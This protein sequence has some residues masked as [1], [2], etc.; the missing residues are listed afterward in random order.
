MKKVSSWKVKSQL[1]VRRQW[2]LDPEAMVGRVLLS[3][4]LVSCLAI[5][6][7]STSIAGISPTPTAVAPENKEALPARI[8]GVL[9]ARPFVFEGRTVLEFNGEPGDAV[10]RDAEGRELVY[11]RSGRFLKLTGVVDRFSVVVHGREMAVVMPSAPKV[12]SHGRVPPTSPSSAEAKQAVLAEQVAE[13]KA[14]VEQLRQ[15]LLKRSSIQT[16]SQSLASAP[17]K[18]QVIE[19]ITI[20]GL[21]KGSAELAADEVT[22]R[23]LIDSAQRAARIEIRA[24][25]SAGSESP[26]THRLA[27]ARAEVARQLLVSHGVDV[28]R[29]VTRAWSHRQFAVSNRTPEGRAANR[30]VEFIFG[31]PVGHRIA[32]Q[33]V[34]PIPIRENA[35]SQSL[36]RSA[37]HRRNPV[38]EAARAAVPLLQC[39]RVEHWPHDAVSF[40][41]ST[42]RDS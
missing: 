41:H 1:A 7:C 11:E 3:I 21:R 35:F 24:Y 32:A 27:I 9:L 12:Q 14:T 39:P 28:Q 33:V 38:I 42:N 2:L 36:F 19:R 22:R 30:R 15:E 8:A 23:Q 6:G 10:I 31:S 18:A 5:A 20:A 37:V 4:V 40:A 34:Q 29:I 25:T 13:M 26:A 16:P 17:V